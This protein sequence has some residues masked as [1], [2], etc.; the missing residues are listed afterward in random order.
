M[1]CH[2][3]PSDAAELL[4]E[5][6]S[7]GAT[8]APAPTQAPATQRA[9]SATQRG[10]KDSNPNP[11]PVKTVTGMSTNS[12]VLFGAT[13]GGNGGGAAGGGGADTVSKQ[14]DSID[15]TR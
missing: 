15:V 2:Q 5:L 8:V 9:G 10:T 6:D 1:F 7:G 13:G 12:M 14:L 3:V 4:A 11:N